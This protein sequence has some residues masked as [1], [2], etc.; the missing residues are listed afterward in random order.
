MNLFL[1]LNILFLLVLSTSFG[2]FTQVA[3]S[4][5]RVGRV[6]VKTLADSVA[7]IYILNSS[8]RKDAAVDLA[9]K[10]YLE[11]KSSNYRF[12]EAES[13][14]AFARLTDSTDIHQKYFHYSS[15]LKVYTIIGDLEKIAVVNLE[16]GEAL[17]SAG[18]IDLAEKHLKVVDSL[19]VVENVRVDRLKLY[20]MLSDCNIKMK[21]FNDAI[22]YLNSLKGYSIQ[23]NDYK[24][25]D[26]SVENLAFCYR[27]K[28]QIDN[29]ILYDLELIERKRRFGNPNEY[30]R[31]IVF[32][33]NDFAAI[34]DFHNAN[35]MLEAAKISKANLKYKNWLVIDE[36]R[37]LVKKGDVIKSRELLESVLMKTTDI[38]LFKSIN[39]EL[40]E[41]YQ[42]V[43][44][45]N[46]LEATWSNIFNICFDS[47]LNIDT[48][49]KAKK[50]VYK[51]L[52]G[53][54]QHEKLTKLNNGIKTD[55]ISL[56]GGFSP[57]NLLKSSILNYKPLNLSLQ[58]DSFLNSVEGI[59]NKIPTIS[60]DFIIDED[61]LVSSQK[62]ADTIFAENKSNASNLEAHSRGSKSLMIITLFGI[63]GLI[64]LVVYF[65][66]RSTK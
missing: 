64:G 22:I 39:V 19:H 60:V 10:I 2:A 20:F 11:S 55:S 43:G 52:M 41:V 45:K 32:A 49:L 59:I 51:Y 66:T 62:T 53:T 6:D 14:L 30:F 54:N 7:K 5:N 26:Y 25:I 27:I 46:K 44:D 17:I 50:L 8:N 38:L 35:L 21:S 61:S 42:I 57:N 36:S 28:N 34:G 18:V 47:T 37:L 65:F 15:A 29:A 24:N 40:F 31:S 3:T 16:M 23:S 4:L 58:T 9:R 12:F 63:A 48:R 13:E 1:K 56:I 33:I